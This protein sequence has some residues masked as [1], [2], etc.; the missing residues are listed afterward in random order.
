ME[1]LTHE[2]GIVTASILVAAIELKYIS[3]MVTLPRKSSHILTFYFP[4]KRLFLSHVPNDFPYQ[5]M[6]KLFVL[7]CNREVGS[8]AKTTSTLTR[9]PICRKASA[10]KMDSNIE[11][12]D[13]RWHTTVSIDT[14]GFDINQGDLYIEALVNFPISFN[15]LGTWLY[16]KNLVWQK[17]YLWR[18]WFSAKCLIKNINQKQIPCQIWWH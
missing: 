17:R 4:C 9:R 12:M 2:A 11:C 14:A 1:E 3:F 10:K 6:Y 18:R 7:S 13:S 8:P 16:T 5:T 15:C